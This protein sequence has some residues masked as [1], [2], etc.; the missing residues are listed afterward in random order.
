[1][2]YIAKRFIMPIVSLFLLASC[3]LGGADSTAENQEGDAK[4]LTFLF[5]IPSQTLDP[6]LDVNYTA[7]RAGVSETLVKISS[8]LTI[9]PWLA[10]D[11]KSKD[12]QTWIFTL[13]GNLTFQN[14]KKADANAV[15]ASLERTIRD[16]EA[17]KN[18]LKI[19]DM[20]AD[21]QTLT[22]TTQEPFPEFPSELVHPNTSI[23]DVSAGD[24]A[25]KPVGTG[26]FQV[27]SFEAGHKI[28][29]ERYDD[30]WD[31]KPKLKH[32]TF[33]FNE[34]ANAR[35]MALQS[36]DA[37]IIYRPSIENIEHIQKDSSII[38]D[39][40]PSLRV[41]QI[42]YNTK[43][44]EL[45]DRHLRRAFDA[46]LDR[47]EI[48][49]S[50]L[51]GHAQPA[52]GPFLADFPFAS[53]KVQKPSGL[54]AAKAEL[55]KAG[56]QLENGKAVKDGKALSF[57]LLTYQS[58]PELPLIAQILESNAKELGIS[59]KIQQVE[60]IDEYLAKNKDWDLATYSSMTAPRG[61]AGY[62]L[63]TAYIPNGAL[64]YS[65]IENQTLIKWI[66]EFNR[67]IEEQKRNR[68]A[69][70]AAELI[71]KETLNSF[72]VTPQNITAYQK[73]VLNW[74]TSQ[75]EY[76]MLTKDLDVKTK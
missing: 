15:K 53:G 34:D 46:L 2:N 66:E 4:K 28:E 37:D 5:N 49:E 51:N 61:D 72:L 67:T 56:Y 19:K 52:D 62:L 35:V 10:K 9:E 75:S 31:G 22:I 21:G 24:I 41:H 20:K 63:N 57:T 33:A 68:L 50:I 43:K 13:K 29:L 12:G 3:S 73:D 32:V 26:P 8:E 65:G 60:N 36:K 47:K 74:K 76:Y 40:V 16:S 23:I 64:N 25:Q 45:A 54:K 30:Y 44:E 14:G 59:I 39:S 69:K 58:R 27:S 48:A 70:K 55:K 6:N 17:M 71:E 1:M 42:L 11:W 18:A 38:V 7:V